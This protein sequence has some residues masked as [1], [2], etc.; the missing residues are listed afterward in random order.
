MID[1]AHPLDL[2]L[3][4]DVEGRPIL[5]WAATDPD[6]DLYTAWLASLM[7]DRRRPA[8]LGPPIPVSGFPGDAI[9]GTESGSHLYLLG[10]ATVTDQLVALAERYADAALAWLVASGVAS[11]VRTT[12]RA[13][14]PGHVE[15]TTTI[16][17]ARPSPRTLRYALSW[18]TAPR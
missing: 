15:L 16:E 14:P 8:H 7:T 12:G 4:L 10:A 17:R 2:P 6:P 11:A 18:P 13:R 9:D 3:R 1:D 5:D